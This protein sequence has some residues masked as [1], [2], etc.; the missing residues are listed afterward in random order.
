[1]TNDPF[2]RDPYG[3]AR[4]RVVKLSKWQAVLIAAV[5]ITLVLT[6]VVVAAGAFLLLFPLVLI[7]GLLL[8]LVA[9]WRGRGASPAGGQPA[10]RGKNGEDIVDAEFV[11]ITD[12]RREGGRHQD[13][14]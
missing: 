10:R 13:E 6:L 8:G 9:R 12:R 2:R 7:G 14:R 4:M 5:A 3:F 1:M 11:V